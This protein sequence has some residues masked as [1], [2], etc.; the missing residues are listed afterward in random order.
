MIVYRV[1]VVVRPAELPRARLM[2]A[3]VVE[4]SRQLPGVHHFDI[5]QDPANECRFVSV[6]VFE[7]QAAVDRQAELPVVAEVLAAFDGLLVDRPRGAIFHVSAT[8]PW[9]ATA[10]TAGSAGQSPHA[11][12]ASPAQT[13]T[14][15]T[16][17]D[18]LRPDGAA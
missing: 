5:L 12:A 16:Q 4:Q 11:T 18:H 14:D 7:D 1:E 9:P 6:E 10:T 3:A 2:F 15:A 13:L 8:Q 17:A